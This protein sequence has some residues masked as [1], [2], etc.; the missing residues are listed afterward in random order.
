M[1]CTLLRSCDASAP[2]TPSVEL[3]PG[4]SFSS[5]HSFCIAIDPTDGGA[6]D[7]CYVCMDSEGGLAPPRRGRCACATAVHD[8]CLRRLVET[9]QNSTCKV[10]TQPYRNVACRRV[11]Y[12]TLTENG[13]AVA[14]YC[15]AV[16]VMPYS[17]STTMAAYAETGAKGWFVLACG[18]ALLF[19]YGAWGLG[20]VAWSRPRLTLWVV[21]HGIVRVEVLPLS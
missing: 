13:Q 1:A 18:F 19:L 20:T 5:D 11:S 7:D 14:V 4:S 21:R 10:C 6:V 17:W 8:E 3:A 16:T 15:L 2:C 9:S 12:R